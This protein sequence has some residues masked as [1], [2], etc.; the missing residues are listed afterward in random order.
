MREKEKSLCV[1][2]MNSGLF[3]CF[4]VVVVVCLCVCVCF[5]CFVVCVCVCVLFFV[6]GAFYFF[7]KSECQ[8]SCGIH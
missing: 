1:H 3:W 5:V 4:F 8:S 2:H 7:A 6:G